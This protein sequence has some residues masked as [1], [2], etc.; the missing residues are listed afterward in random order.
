MVSVPVR[1]E[2]LGF[3]CTRKLTVPLPL[4]FCPEVIVR[5]AELLDADHA[6]PLEAETLTLPVPP[7]SLNDW[8]VGEITKLQLTPVCVTVKVCP[9]TVIVPVRVAES[10]FGCTK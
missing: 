2:L 4:P 5:N 6:Q 7:V 1:D 10:L 9:A 8:L 3:D